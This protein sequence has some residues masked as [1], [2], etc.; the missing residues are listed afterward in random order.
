LGAETFARAYP[1]ING[2]ANLESDLFV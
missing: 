2:K 1:T